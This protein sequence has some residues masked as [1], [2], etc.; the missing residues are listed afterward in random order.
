MCDKILS[1]G[2]KN[3]YKIYFGQAQKI[4]NMFF[5]YMLLVD[6]RLNCHLNYF[7]VP[8]DGVILKGLARNQEYSAELRAYA[9]A[10]M[11]W[12]KMEDIKIYMQ[13]QKELRE[14][15]EFPIIFEFSY[16]PDWKK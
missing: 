8:C 13:L 14:L 16:W 4:I 1:V 7:H 10:C 2:E 12:S 15:Y 11:P 3:G 6:E 9:K 5:K